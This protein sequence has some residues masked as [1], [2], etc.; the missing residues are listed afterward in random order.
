MK[1]RNI[2]LLACVTMGTV[3]ASCEYDNYEAPSRLFSGQLKCDGE[4]FPYD[5]NR[6]LFRFLQ[7]GFGK[8]D[9]GTGMRV[10]DD[11]HYQQL[12]FN[13]D[14]KLTLVNQQL[15][16]EIPELGIFKAGIGYDSIAYHIQSDV[17]KDFEV[18]PF[19]KISN[20]NAELSGNKIVATFDV[21]KMT[22]TVK[23]PPRIKRTYIYLSTSKLVN[24]NIKC[25]KLTL[26]SATDPT[27]LQAS[28]PLAE[29]RKKQYYPN[30]FR[31]YAF[32]RV[33]IELDG[34]PDYYLFSE[35]KKIENLPVE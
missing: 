12:L 5:S 15:P 26:I 8:V 20:L 14:Y 21:T 25:Q 16:F 35:V 11:G 2:L 28:I 13:D 1:I 4:N 33:A 9:G 23:E 18:K 22:N 31:T 17:V 30:N 29:Y 24:S 27:T 19:Y 6:D 3:L 34:I 10:D 7:S 32:Y